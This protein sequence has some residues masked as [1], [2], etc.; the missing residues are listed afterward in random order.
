[1]VENK[2][3]AIQCKI[4]NYRNAITD[5]ALRAHLYIRSSSDVGSQILSARIGATS[6]ARFVQYA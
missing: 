3:K 6:A 1:M 4:A 2:N 5:E